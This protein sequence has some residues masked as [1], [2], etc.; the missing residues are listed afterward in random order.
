MIYAL[1][2]TKVTDHKKNGL[3]MQ[4]PS[5]YDIKD[6]EKEATELAR[7]LSSKTKNY[8]I[9]CK[10]YKIETIFEMERVLEESKEYFKNIYT[11]MLEAKEMLTKRK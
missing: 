3:V 2:Y 9:I 8:I 6:S 4:Q 7:S 1:I 5:I 11:N 10:I